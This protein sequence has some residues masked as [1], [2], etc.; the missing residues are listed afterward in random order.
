MGTNF[1]PIFELELPV[2]QDI[3]FHHELIGT[4]DDQLQWGAGRTGT[5]T[6]AGGMGV[7]F[8]RGFGDFSGSPSPTLIATSA[9]MVAAY[10]I[11]I[12]LDL[13]AQ[14]FNVSGTLAL[15]A[16][17]PGE[18][19]WAIIT[20][21]YE[22]IFTSVGGYYY[23]DHIWDFSTATWHFEADSVYPT[24]TIKGWAIFETWARVCASIG[25]NADA[26]D[27]VLF[28]RRDSQPTSYGSN[29]CGSFTAVTS[30]LSIRGFNR[31]AYDKPVTCSLEDL[32]DACEALWDIGMGVEN[33]KVKV[34]T[35]SYFYD[36]NTVIFSATNI[37]HIKISV[38]EDLI[39]NLLEIGFKKWQS[40]EV[41]GLDAINTNYQYSLPNRF[42]KNET[43]KL[44]P[45]I[46]DGYAI[47]LTRRRDK[48]YEPTT[49]YA[50]DNEV[51]VICLNRS[52]DAGGVPTDL[53]TPEVDENFSSVNGLLHEETRYN[54]RVANTRNLLR[55]LESLSG[56]LPK[57]PGTFYKIQYGEANLTWDSTMNADNCP[58]DFSAAL[59]AAFANLQWDDG[60]IR[61]AAP[62][63]VPELI[64]FE[65][66]VCYDAYKAIKANPKGVVEYNDDNGDIQAGYIINLDYSLADQMGRFKLLRAFTG[67]VVEPPPVN[68]EQDDIAIWLESAEINVVKDGGNLV[69]TWFDISGNNRDHSQN[70]GIDKPIWVD[71]VTPNGS[72]VVRFD[73]DFLDMLADY[74]RSGGAYTVYCY[75]K[76]T[77]L[78]GVGGQSLWGQDGGA[79]NLQHFGGALNTNV[80]ATGQPF[81]NERNTLNRARS[82]ANF[83][84]LWGVLTFQ[85]D[86]ILLDD[87]DGAYSI[88]QLID[89]MR[90]RR[91]GNRTWNTSFYFVGDTPEFI[92]YSVKHN[93]AQKTAV[94][95][96][97]R[98]KHG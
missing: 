57:K 82:D 45:Y 26:F 37:P 31:S 68:P 34:E 50:Y 9:L 52:E 74:V 38:A 94:E 28:G 89:D 93:A 1:E 47:E 56:E 53:D 87:T 7:A 13:G 8:Y 86:E 20:Y 10:A 58:G 25:D 75:L 83:N 78:N 16:M 79:G 19:I 44:S 30:G 29:G 60:D 64:E 72:P 66:P 23:Y 39:Y 6:L 63:W 18:R 43:T 55:A 49:D 27:S 92:V 80:L 73:D 69:E 2:S 17:Q 95:N 36:K 96:Y 62:L 61:N 33:N 32:F 54:L 70:V 97:L 71:G 42:I 88:A 3:T 76:T 81:E 91:L 85:E 59:L 24:S 65:Y 77:G 84:G 15:A 46:G 48:V 11:D 21:N 41:N 67:S 98:A 5:R 4:F 90:F 12:N 22:V 14:A 51:F 40:Q 35:K